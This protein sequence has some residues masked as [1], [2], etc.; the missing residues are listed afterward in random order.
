M[1]F[2][3]TFVAEGGQA[4]S[5]KNES[6]DFRET[7]LLLRWLN[8]QES[9]TRKDQFLSTFLSRRG[10]RRKL[11]NLEMH[12]FDSTIEMLTFSKSFLF[13]LLELS[14]FHV[15]IILIEDTRAVL[16]CRC[17]RLPSVLL[18]VFYN[19]RLALH[20]Q[21]TNMLTVSCVVFSDS[22]DSSTNQFEISKG[23]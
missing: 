9:V 12:F 18:S 19:F 14:C 1:R 22:Q 7:R 11:V 16:L 15:L 5:C 13:A 4:R 6:R 3:S 23:C 17:D 20:N 8:L 10:R 2:K 21:T